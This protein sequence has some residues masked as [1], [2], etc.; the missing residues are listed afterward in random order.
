MAATRIN[1]PSLFSEVLEFAAH[2]VAV[3]A[4]TAANKLCASASSSS[5]VDTVD[6][7]A[8]VELGAFDG[9]DI[10]RVAHC[11]S[12]LPQTGNILEHEF[13]VIEAKGEERTRFFSLEKVNRGSGNLSTIEMHEG[14]RVS[15]VFNK[16][17]ADGPPRESPRRRLEVVPEAPVPLRRVLQYVFSHMD[18][19]FSV[20]SHNC[21]DFASE[22]VDLIR[23]AAQTSVVSPLATEPPAQAPA[24]A[25]AHAVEPAAGTACAFAF[26]TGP[27]DVQHA[28]GE[29]AAGAAIEATVPAVVGTVREATTTDGQR[30][31][32]IFP[33][34]LH[35]SAED[36][37]A[38]SEDGWEVISP[39]QR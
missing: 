25:P 36:E 8:M 1:V 9:Y 14:A 3:C 34:A 2:A 32:E 7:L 29:E 16:A 4:D 19:P 24:A 37:G 17:G 15:E 21:Q 30:V 11:A 39:G 6:Y 35:A 28:V 23:L 18:K 12:P 20:H 26:E 38:G 22:V 31:H 13:V 5:T 10:T 33:D 27:L